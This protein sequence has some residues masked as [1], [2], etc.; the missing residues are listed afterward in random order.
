MKSLTNVV[1]NIFEPGINNT[2]IKSLLLLFGFIQQINMHSATIYV[3]E[4]KNRCL[5]SRGATAYK[6]ISH[7]K[8][9]ATVRLVAD[10]T[11]RHYLT[12]L[13]KGKRG[14]GVIIS[15]ASVTQKAKGQ[16]CFS[17]Q[18]FV[19]IVEVKMPVLCLSC[20]SDNFY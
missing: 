1:S 11:L 20:N 10:V 12:S 7:E 17:Q 6:Y 5:Y 8:F 16:R 18:G 4:V 2:H 3:Q 13:T 9:H 15:C 19:F 14:P